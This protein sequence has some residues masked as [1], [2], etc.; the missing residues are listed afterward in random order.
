VQLEDPQSMIL[1]QNV[2]P[3]VREDVASNSTATSALDAVQAA[4]TTEDL[5][6]LNKKVDSER[7]DPDQVAGEWLTS[8]GLA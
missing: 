3:L 1:P 2:I 7:Q 8:K 4:L 5:M 6:A